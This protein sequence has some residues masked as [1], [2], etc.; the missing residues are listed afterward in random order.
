MTHGRVFGEGFAIAPDTVLFADI[1]INARLLWIILQRHSDPDGR[2]YP[3]RKRLATIMGCSEVT[4]TR[5]K[6]ELSDAGL[7]IVK[8]RFDEAGRR[9]T[10]DLFLRH[11]RRKNDAT[12]RVVFAPTNSKAVELEP[13]EPDF[14]PGAA[15][16]AAPRPPTDTRPIPAGKPTPAERETALQK[17]REI[18][19]RQEG[20]G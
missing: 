13:E 9:T 19:Q 2:C 10:D 15:K 17:L 1:S 4:V 16:P 12:G 18:R 11:A 8:E 20:T 7:L 5:A 14:A 6:K 3:G